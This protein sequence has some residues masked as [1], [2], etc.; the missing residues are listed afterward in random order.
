LKIDDLVMQL[1]APS[2]LWK[3]GDEMPCLSI[4]RLEQI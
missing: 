2:L 4:T 3:T 1:F